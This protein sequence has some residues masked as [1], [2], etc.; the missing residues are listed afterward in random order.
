[1][2]ELDP[3]DPFEDILIDMVEIHRKKKADYGADN[4]P[5]SNFDKVAALVPVP[6]YDSTMD[7][8][9]MVIRKLCRIEN[10]VNKNCGFKVVAANESLEDSM[11]DLAVYSVLLIELYRRDYGRGAAG[12]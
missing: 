10:L 3:S 2:T 11:I 8:L 12:T 6:E 7:C 9:T 5:L 1:M 4:N